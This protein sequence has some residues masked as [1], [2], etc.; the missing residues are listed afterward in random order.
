L[1][2]IL[3]VN[4]NDFLKALVG[5]KTERQRAL[6]VEVLRPA[7]DDAHDRRVWLAPDEAHGFLARDLSQRRD[8]LAYCRADARHAEVSTVTKLFCSYPSGMQ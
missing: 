8:L 2:L 7:R 4:A 3:N 1:Q 5:A 6:G